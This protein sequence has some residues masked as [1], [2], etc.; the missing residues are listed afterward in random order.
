MTLITATP[1]PYA[2]KVRVVL[3]DPVVVSVS[4]CLQARVCCVLNGYLID[5]RWDALYAISKFANH[6]FALPASQS[7]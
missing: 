4:L 2:R 1:S 3:R 5:R 6:R 7:G